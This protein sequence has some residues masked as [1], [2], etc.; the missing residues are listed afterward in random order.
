MSKEMWDARSV[1]KSPLEMQGALGIVLAEENISG[2]VRGIDAY[3]RTLRG[4]Q[5]ELHNLGQKIDEEEFSIIL[6]SSIPETS[7]R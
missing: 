3:F 4:Y 7:S 1:V 2:S 6:L 5:V